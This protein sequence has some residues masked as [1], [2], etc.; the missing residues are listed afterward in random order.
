MSANRCKYV[1]VDLKEN[2][3]LAVIKAVRRVFGTDGT[4]ITF[5]MYQ[6]CIEE[7]AKR[8]NNSIPKPPGEQ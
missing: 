5:Q 3:N 1:S 8:S 6:R 7:L 4:K 2:D